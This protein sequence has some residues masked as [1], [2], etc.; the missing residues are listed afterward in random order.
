MFRRFKKVLLQTGASKGISSRDILVLFLV[1]ETASKISGDFP[2]TVY[3]SLCPGLGVTL[4]KL[5]FRE[6][7][8]YNVGSMV[9]LPK[10]SSGTTPDSYKTN[11]L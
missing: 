1:K 8:Y 10:I 7:D 2:G 9:A 11:L 5:R 6:M 4:R 3:V